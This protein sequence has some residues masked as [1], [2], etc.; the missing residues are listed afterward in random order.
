MAIDRRERWRIVAGV[1]LGLLVAGALSWAALRLVG[2]SLWLMPPLG[3]SAV[4][5]FGLPASP[6]AQPWSVVG[7]NTVSAMVG[8]GITAF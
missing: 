2:A 3:A 7:G 1:A 8:V 5:V 4:L 6:L